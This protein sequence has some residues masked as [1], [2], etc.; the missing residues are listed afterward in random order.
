[1]LS[2]EGS[3]VL[4][5]PSLGVLPLVFEEHRHLKRQ[6]QTVMPTLQA[7]VT[8]CYCLKVR[9]RTKYCSRQQLKL[10]RF[11]TRAG[12]HGSRSLTA[13]RGRPP[14]KRKKKLFTD[15]RRPRLL[16]EQSFLRKR[17]GPT[18]CQGCHSV[19]QKKPQMSKTFQSHGVQKPPLGP[20]HVPLVSPLI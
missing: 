18:A 8:Y 9:N 19:T 20:A 14:S 16:R 15:F 11:Q 10:S 7:F 6:R 5:R 1:M 12:A 3:E 4:L 2:D 17:K 13:E